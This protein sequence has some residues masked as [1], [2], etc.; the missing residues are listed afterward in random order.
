MET[1]V[2]QPSLDS[3]TES[4]LPRGMRTRLYKLFSQIESEFEREYRKLYVENLAREFGYM[5]SGHVARERASRP[6]ECHW[7][8]PDVLH[9]R[10]EAC[11]M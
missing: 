4:M 9:N 6:V 11:R 3:S 10:N 2:P 7:P 8:V 1:F 5:C